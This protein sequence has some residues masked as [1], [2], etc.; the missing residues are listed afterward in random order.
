V[1][2]ANVEWERERGVRKKKIIINKLLLCETVNIHCPFYKKKKNYNLALLSER[3][4][5]SW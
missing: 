1:G 2:N 3:K 4:R 5:K